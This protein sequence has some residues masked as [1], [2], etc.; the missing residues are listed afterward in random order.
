MARR[1]VSCGFAAGAGPERA[2]RWTWP[3]RAGRLLRHRPRRRARQQ[4]LAV[5]TA[6]CSRVAGRAAGWR[7]RHRRGVCRQR[8]VRHPDRRAG[9]KGW[10]R[11]LGGIAVGDALDHR[12]VQPIGQQL[13]QLHGAG[14]SAWEV[15]LEFAAREARQDPVRRRLRGHDRGHRELVQ[16]GQGRLDESGVDQVHADPQRMQVEVQRLGQVD[17]RRLGRP[18]DQRHRQAVESGD[19]RDDA[20]R[21][22]ALADQHRHDRGQTVD[23]AAQVRLHDP[24]RIGQVEVVGAHRPVGACHPEHHVDALPP[25]DDRLQRVAHRAGLGDVHRQDQRRAGLGGRAGQFAKRFL[26]PRRQRHPGAAGEKL[27]RNRRADAAGGSDDPDPPAAPVAH[28][29]IQ[30]RQ[31][32]GPQRRVSERVT[33]PNRIPNLLMVARFSST[34]SS[35]RNIQ[36]SKSTCQTRPSTGKAIT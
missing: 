32:G 10:R 33:S 9:R 25:I 23:H 18:V 24:M 34:R 19:A 30:G 35:T 31:H 26:A 8:K 22:A 7:R 27:A 5:A 20:D 12:E 11:A 13:Q 14:E 17:Q 6:S 28:A 2:L 15:G 1:P 36:S 21:A 3:R 29:G 16:F 4:A